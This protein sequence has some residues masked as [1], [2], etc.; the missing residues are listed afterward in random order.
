MMNRPRAGP[1]TRHR[2]EMR[3]KLPP[4]GPSPVPT[5]TD[6]RARVTAMSTDGR[7]AHFQPPPE[8]AVLGQP[9]RVY[10]STGKW[11]R[12][13]TGPIMTD[14]LLSGAWGAIAVAVLFVGLIVLFKGK[15]PPGMAGL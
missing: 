14:G 11:A 10:E 15:T 13:V 8:V 2:P 1:A 4:D 3:S 9:L 7:A 5:L 6:K 12:A